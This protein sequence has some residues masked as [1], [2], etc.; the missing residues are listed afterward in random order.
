LLSLPLCGDFVAAERQRKRISA[1]LGPPYLSA[2]G[3]A[4][5]HRV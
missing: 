5:P 2:G 1:G 3:A 4:A